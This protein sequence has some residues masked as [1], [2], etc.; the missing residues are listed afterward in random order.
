MLEVDIERPLGALTLRAAFG[1]SAGV[2]ALFGRSGAGKTS[3]VNAVAGLLR[4][5]S[6]RIL[7]DGKPLFDA[8]VGLDVPRHRRRIGYVFQEP[9]LFPHLSV[10]RNLLYGRWFTAAARRRGSLDEVVA[11]LGLVPLLQRRPG[12]LSGGEKQRVA[13]G[14]ALLASPRLLLMDEPLASLDHQRK[15]EILP[16]LDR[17]RVESGVPILYVSHALDE[18]TRLADTLVLVSEGQV[19]AAGPIGEIMA[20]LDLGPLTGRAEAGSILPAIVIGQHEAYQLTEL[21]VLGQPLLMP[22]VDAAAGT[23]VRLRVRARDVAVATRVPEDLSI[24]N[25]L[26]GRIADV[27]PEP[28]P[29]AELTIDLG[30]P[31]LR[32]R[33]TRHAVDELGLVPGRPVVALI[34]AAAVE[35]R[36]L[37]PGT[38]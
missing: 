37:G 32:A 20:R 34:K 35:R 2:T 26:F 8:A 12:L 15:E 31:L 25:Q 30:G 29:F 13:I 7:L 22:R 24:R 23:P 3:I 10:R 6:G 17:L 9:R 19:A 16:Y 14:R 28:G 11:L 38:S 27:R 18:V 1:T 5:T 21:A 36:L 33:L 4:P